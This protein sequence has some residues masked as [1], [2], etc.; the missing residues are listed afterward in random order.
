MKNPY[1]FNLVWLSILVFVLMIIL[2]CYCSASII[3]IEE[4]SH[5]QNILLNILAAALLISLQELILFFRDK[6]KNGLLTG[7]YKRISIFQINKD[8]KQWDAKTDSLLLSDKNVEYKQDSIYHRLKVYDEQAVSLKIRL[9]HLY[10]G[11]YVGKAE[12]N[13]GSTDIAIS[14][15]TINTTQG[16]GTYSYYRRNDSNLP[17]NG[18]YEIQI[19]NC[20]SSRVTL[21]VYYKNTIPTG[22]AEGY[23]IWEKI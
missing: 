13:E 20:K 6:K 11:R 2:F 9:K 8:K 23:E 4:N 19:E 22:A 21:Y 10:M 12:Y 18:T 17:D 7:N 16:K 5:S 14:L 3:R 15:D 1:L